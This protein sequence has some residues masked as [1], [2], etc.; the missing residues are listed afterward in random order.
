MADSV[1]CVDVNFIKDMVD[2]MRQRADG[3]DRT[4]AWVRNEVMSFID[5]DK[6]KIKPQSKK[7]VAK[8]LQFA[9]FYCNIFHN[10]FFTGIVASPELLVH[11]DYL[12]DKFCVNA[13]R[14]TVLEILSFEV[15]RDWKNKLLVAKASPA[16]EVTIFCVPYLNA[17]I[18]SLSNGSMER[19]E[20]KN[21]LHLL[22]TRID[23]AGK[24]TVNWWNP[25]FP[26]GLIFYNACSDIW[27]AA[28]DADHFNELLNK[29]NIF[30]NR[31]MFADRRI[32]FKLK[33]GEVFSNYKMDPSIFQE[34]LTKARGNAATVNRS[35][36]VLA[37]SPTRTRS[38][39]RS[40]TPSAKGP[41]FASLSSDELTDIAN[42]AS[43]VASLAEKGAGAK[44][45][46]SS[47]AALR[48]TDNTNKASSE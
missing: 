3:L 13:Q 48:L 40:P 31:N 2:E 12:P 11:L 1:I 35:S 22:E 27:L 38:V 39:I 14:L 46:S 43:S 34:F 10:H 8:L 23:S 17:C 7:Q 42:K 44:G 41:L 19:M 36:V 37:A 9:N 5:E 47:S 18:K 25:S 21:E 20:L 26:E 6:Q 45:S 28:N 32:G 30:V 24:Q 15:C 16:L 4:L 29:P 33:S